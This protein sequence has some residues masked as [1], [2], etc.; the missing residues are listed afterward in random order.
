MKQAN[1][2]VHLTSTN[3]SYGLS[4]FPLGQYMYIIAMFILPLFHYY[5]FSM[6]LNF[7]LDL[8]CSTVSANS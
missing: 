4:A 5:L 3:I 1:T 7:S 6:S 8:L 2:N